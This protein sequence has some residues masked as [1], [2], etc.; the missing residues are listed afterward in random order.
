MKFGLMRR[1]DNWAGV[2]LCLGLGAID[3]VLNPLRRVPAPVEP[4]KVRRVLVMKFIGLG[5]L[6]EAV[7][8]FRAMRRHYPGARISFLTFEWSADLVRLLGFDEVRVIRTSTFLRF[9]WDGIGAV[10]WGWGR[11]FEVSHDLEFF[12]KFSYIMSYLV[13]ART[14]V[15]YFVR[16]LRYIRLLTHPVPYNP[17]RHVVEAFLAQLGMEM[18]DL[19]DE[20]AAPPALGDDV[21]READEVLRSAGLWGATCLVAI[22]VNTGEMSELRLWPLAYHA[23]LAARIHSDHGAAIA[24]IGSESDRARIRQV[25]GTLPANIRKADLSGLT[26][27][28]VLLAILKRC[29]LVVSNDSG[30]LHLAALMGVPTVG[31]F[32]AESARVYGPRGAHHVN[33]E[34][35][36]YCAPCLNV[37]NFKDFDCPYGVKCMGEISPEEAFAAASRLLAERQST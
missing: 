35:S 33:L 10:L 8:M 25:M 19:R 37:Y 2:P 31:F 11:R 14:R 23:T 30:P 3:A 16:V 12:S 1:I 28:A 27:V 24:F 17:H 32:G 22:N 29:R 26:R 15:G 7:P 34:K 9:A 20:D 6:A 5:T 13:H 18:S 36:L 21:E 4:G